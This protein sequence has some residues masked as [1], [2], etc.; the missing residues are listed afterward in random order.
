MVTTMG[1]VAVANGAYVCAYLFEIKWDGF[2][3]ICYVE[4]DG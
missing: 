1:C 3:A 4:G 2:R